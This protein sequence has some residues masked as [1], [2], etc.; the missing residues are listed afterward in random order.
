MKK[1]PINWGRLAV[2]L[3]AAVF[4]F[5]WWMGLCVCVHWVLT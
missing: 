2:W 3:G 4:V 5:I 1:E